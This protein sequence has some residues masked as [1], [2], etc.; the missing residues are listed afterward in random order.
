M[1]DP[2]LGS[3]GG[4]RMS[5][6]TNVFV[7]LKSCLCNYMLILITVLRSDHKYESTSGYPTF[8]SHVIEAIKYKNDHL[9]LNKVTNAHA[10]PVIKNKIPIK[11]VECSNVRNSSAFKINY[12]VKLILVTC[13]MTAHIHSENVSKL[14]QL[15]QNS[16]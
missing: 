15:L 6:C 4:P 9:E 13:S 5:V 7:V 10:D 16:F 3:I 14:I 12:S 11:R 1:K 2:L 8:W